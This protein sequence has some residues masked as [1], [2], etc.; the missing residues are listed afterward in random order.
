MPDNDPPAPGPE[1]VAPVDPN[2]PVNPITPV[3]P[4]HG[5]KPTAGLPDLD[6]FK[7]LDEEKRYEM[8]KDY[9]WEGKTPQ[10]TLHKSYAR[11]IRITQV[12]A[13]F[14]KALFAFEKKIQA[15][16]KEHPEDKWAKGIVAM[17]E[18]LDKGLR[19]YWK[20]V[21]IEADGLLLT[22]RYPRAKASFEGPGDTIPDVPMEISKDKKA[23]KPVECPDEREHTELVSRRD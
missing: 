7:G 16:L 5:T 21:T 8:L 6:T 9:Y 3:N 12:L 2:P 17:C 10:D 1:P 22:G 23:P 20:A 4:S 13:A 14:E 11:A 18:A 19:K 15:R